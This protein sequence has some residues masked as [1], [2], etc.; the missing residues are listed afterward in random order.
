MTLN[1]ELW[2]AKNSPTRTIDIDGTRSP[3]E[4][5]DRTPAFPLCSFTTSPRSSTTGTPGY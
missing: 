1:T 4:S 5:S 3:I 2:N